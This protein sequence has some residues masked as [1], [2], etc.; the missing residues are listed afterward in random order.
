MSRGPK[1]VTQ[2]VFSVRDCNAN[3]KSLYVFGDNLMRFGTGGQAIIRYC[4]N[5]HG[6]ITKRAPNNQPDAYFNDSQLDTFKE[7]VDDDIAD[8]LDKAQHYEVVVLPSNGL[9]TGLSRLPTVAPLCFQYLCDK[10]FQATGL[11][12]TSKGFQ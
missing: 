3:P 8:M 12:Q 10:L 4:A 11:R 5:S 6:V 9:G 1:F 7:C 2:S